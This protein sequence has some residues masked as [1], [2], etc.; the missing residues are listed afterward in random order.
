MTLSLQRTGRLTA[1]LILVLFIVV[2]ASAGDTLFQY[3]TIDALLA[4]VYDGEM[5]M[6]ALRH[7]GDFG[8]GTL[9]GLDGEL[10]V[11]DGTA[12]HVSRRRHG[13]YPCRLG[14]GPL[15][16]CLLFSRKTPFS[17]WNGPRA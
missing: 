1:S 6:E 12:Y 9:N 3:S 17:N 4:G 14:Q 13:G 15:C 11:L 16:R 2:Q 7:K 10:V 8:L 5:T